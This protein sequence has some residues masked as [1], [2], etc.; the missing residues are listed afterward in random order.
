MRDSSRW[1]ALLTVAGFVYALAAA[2]A[3]RAATPLTVAY[4]GSMGAVMDNGLGP[5]FDAA[6]GTRFRGIGEGAYGLARLIAAKQLRAD[7]FVAITPGPI[8]VVQQAGL[9]DAAVPVAS[10]EMVIAWSP[11][12]RFAKDFAAAAKGA[13]PWYAVLQQ[14]GM[15]FGRTDPRTDPQGRNIVLTMQLA[16][17]YYHQPGLVQKI[18]GPLD[19]P[20][21][22]FTEPSLLTRLEAGQVDASSGYLSAVVSH[23]LPYIRLP[24]E[25][26]LG[27]PAMAHRWY[28]RAGF[29]LPGSDGGR[30]KVTAEPL[31]FYAGVLKNAA[32]PRL[33]ARFIEFLRSPAGQAVLA[34]YGYGGASD[35]PLRP[36]K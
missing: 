8:R 9:M 31:V 2:P 23:H 17:A 27:D 5:A 20:R 13:L 21:Q 18:L 35:Q 11:K 25:I 32:H 14:P 24:A 7:V 30:K 28:D 4:A 29:T 3:A 10:T 19:N 12:S 34:E 1:R 22:I 36:A 16:E 6:N 26:D 33:A 15:R